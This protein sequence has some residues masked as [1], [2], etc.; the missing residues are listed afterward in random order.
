MAQQQRLSSRI[1]RRPEVELA[2][3]SNR[4]TIY[5]EIKDGLFTKP[6][7]LSAR[8]VGW[9]EAEVHAVNAARI[10]GWSDDDIRALVKR[11]EARRA[12][13]MVDLAEAA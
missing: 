4:S 11:L 9:P 2:R 1:Y 10:A 6:V 3:G 5:S 8:S 13:A 12:N 7:K